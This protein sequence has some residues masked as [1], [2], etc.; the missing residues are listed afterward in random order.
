M[1]QPRRIAMAES[2]DLVD[3]VVR[4]I[5]GTQALFPWSEVSYVTMFPRHVEQCC[6]AHMT[7]EDVSMRT[8]LDV[9]LTRTSQSCFWTM[10]RE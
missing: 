9:T 4:M 8:V 1:T 10:T 7:S 6:T 2:R 5:R 3:R